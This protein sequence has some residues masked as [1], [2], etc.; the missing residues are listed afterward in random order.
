MLDFFFLP[1]V[2]YVFFSV[3]VSI[4]EHLRIEDSIAVVLLSQDY[5]FTRRSIHIIHSVFTVLSM[6]ITRSCRNS[7]LPSLVHSH[8]RLLSKRMVCQ[9]IAVIL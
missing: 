7:V 4:T 5:H 1:H 3:H 8:I 6:D 9:D 2:A